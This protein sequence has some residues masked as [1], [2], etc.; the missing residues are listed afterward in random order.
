MAPWRVLV[1]DKCGSLRSPQPSTRHGKANREMTEKPSKTG[2]PKSI[3]ELFGKRSRNGA[4]LAGC[5]SKPP[6]SEV[7]GDE[8]ARRRGA[9]PANP[10][11]DRLPRFPPRNAFFHW[12]YPRSMHI[13]NL[14]FR[15]A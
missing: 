2:L 6:K 8:K 10:L 3:A 9:V 14:L 11:G 1:I 13:L 5:F 15:Q 12:F 7:Y 4:K